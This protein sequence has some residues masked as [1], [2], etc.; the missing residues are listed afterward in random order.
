MKLEPAEKL[1]RLALF[2]NLLLLAGSSWTQAGQATTQVSV[3]E[4]AKVHYQQARE[5]QRQEQDELALAEIRKALELSANYV[6]AHRLYVELQLGLTG[7]T[8]D[9]LRDYREKMKQEPENPVYPLVLADTWPLVEDQKERE[10]LYSRVA[11]LAPEWSWGQYALGVLQQQFRS[12]P[13]KAIEAFRKS[14]ELESDNIRFYESLSGA[15]KQAGR[16][17]EAAAAWKRML[18]IGAPHPC[19]IHGQGQTSPRQGP[20]LC[21]ACRGRGHSVSA[22]PPAAVD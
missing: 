17:E 16:D 19:R 20:G 22:S 5:L 18:E 6:E 12:D 3:L 11:E 2:L 8:P 4:Q 14:A 7:S 9:L 13:G 10:H 15:L 1:S 21:P